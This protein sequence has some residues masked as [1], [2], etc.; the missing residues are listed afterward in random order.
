[1]SYALQTNIPE[2][3]MFVRTEYFT[4]QTLEYLFHL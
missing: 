3:E 1:M 4:N 2:G